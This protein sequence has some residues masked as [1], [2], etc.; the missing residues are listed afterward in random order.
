MLV[1]INGGTV[2]T[3]LAIA[4]F[5]FAI[6]GILGQY[7]VSRNTA[8]LAQYRDIAKAWEDKARVQE[9]EIADLQ[10]DARRKESVIAELTGKVNV[11]QDTLTGKASWDILE[12]RISEALVIVAETRAEV[13]DI[14]ETILAQR[15]PHER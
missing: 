12:A 8:A 6:V 1:S 15:P 10:N 7:R 2:V 4:S 3:F 11:L 5:V 9:A 14:H 13:S